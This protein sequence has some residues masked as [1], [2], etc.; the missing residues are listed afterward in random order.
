MTSQLLRD[1]SAQFVKPRA[2][3]RP[4]YTVRVHER[5]QEGN[6]ERVQIFE[7]LVISVH[8]GMTPTD[9]TFTV[10]RIASGIGVEKIFPL[11]SPKIEKIEI[12]KVAKVRRAKLFFLRGRRGKA[13]RLSE[14]F[15]TADEFAVAVEKEEDK[16]DTEQDVIE[17]VIEEAVEEKV[18]TSEETP[19]KEE[20]PAETTVEEPAAEKKVEEAPVEEAKEEPAKEEESEEKS[21]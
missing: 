20:Q 7:G 18:E 4:G 11:H 15:T 6:K 8:K 12:K 21:E 5:I 19:K 10:R 13:A 1:Q 3:I 17:E 14:R 2:E 9:S 16:V